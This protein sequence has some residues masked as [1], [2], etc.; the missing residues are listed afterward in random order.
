MVPDIDLQL[1]VVG[2][3]LR[4]VVAQADSGGGLSLEQLN[5]SIVTL[6]QAR[7]LMP[8][9]VEIARRELDVSIRMAEAVA[10]KIPDAG[11]GGP[12]AGASAV[13]NDVHAGPERID[14]ARDDLNAAI[15]ALV[16]DLPSDDTGREVM[17]IMLRHS[18]EALDIAR[19]CCL[20][21]GFETDPGEVERLGR[22]RA[23]IL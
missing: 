22:L 14:A 10:E 15:G 19:A 12:I 21:A 17:R 20:S 16:A 9:R 1:E 11:L 13:R 7:S 8:A 5:L 4:N 6:N 23:E 2:A 18:R 3:A